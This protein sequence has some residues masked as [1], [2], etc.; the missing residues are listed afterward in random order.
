M[1]LCEIQI[2][3][4][5]PYMNNCALTAKM[6]H[7]SPASITVVLDLAQDESKIFKISCNSTSTS[8]S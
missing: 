2:L 3:F 6:V 7:A 1:V 8:Q 5:H 4:Y